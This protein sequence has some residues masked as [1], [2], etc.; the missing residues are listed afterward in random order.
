MVIA[1]GRTR[2]CDPNEHH[3]EL[4]QSTRMSTHFGRLK[5]NGNH[6][7]LSRNKVSIAKKPLMIE[8]SVCKAT[9]WT[10]ADATRQNPTHLS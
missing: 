6:V 2:A 3:N 4:T 10:N 8:R 9:A 5:T 1:D 7:T